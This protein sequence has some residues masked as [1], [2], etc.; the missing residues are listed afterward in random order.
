MLI[1]IAKQGVKFSSSTP[2]WQQTSGAMEVCPR[3]N[4]LETDSEREGCMQRCPWEWGLRR[5]GWDRG[6]GLSCRGSPGP[7]RSNRS[8][9][10]RMCPNGGKRAW[11]GLSQWEAEAPPRHVWPWASAFSAAKG[12]HQWGRPLRAAAFVNASL[13]NLGTG[14]NTLSSTVRRC[15]EWAESYRGRRSLSQ[16][17]CLE[18]EHMSSLWRMGGLWRRNCLTD[19]GGWDLPPGR[20]TLMVQIAYS[21]FHLWKAGG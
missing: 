21:S 9:E 17:G 5:Q 1:C 14:Q 4:T 7:R 11:L 13:L 2:S 18:A 10:A 20:P 3:P 16:E 15:Q 6:G 19:A 8:S 12:S